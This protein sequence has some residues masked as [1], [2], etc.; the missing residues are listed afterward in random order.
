MKCRTKTLM[1]YL[2]S[3]SAMQCNTVK[4]NHRIIK[5]GCKIKSWRNFNQIKGDQIK[6]FF[7][8]TNRN[9]VANVECPVLLG[10]LCKWVDVCRSDWPERHNL[11]MLWL[12]LLKIKSSHGKVCRRTSTSCQIS[13]QNHA[14]Q[15]RV[16]QHH[17]GTP[18]AHQLSS[19][20][21]SWSC[22]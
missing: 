20:H 16:E 10:V 21:C 3:V 9:W 12:Y 17:L 11:A 15:A 6:V 7:V 5:S 8:V 13:F 4:Q 2:F 19:Y 18:Q 14:A 1:G 22:P